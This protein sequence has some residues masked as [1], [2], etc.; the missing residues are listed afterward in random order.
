MLKRYPYLINLVNDLADLAKA[1]VT[2]NL[3]TD[4]SSGTGTAR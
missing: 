3:A 1:Y 4:R 2:I